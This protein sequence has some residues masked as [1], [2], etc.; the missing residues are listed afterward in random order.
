M[1]Q[2]TLN[3]LFKE[4]RFQSST[5]ETVMFNMAQKAMVQEFA[6]LG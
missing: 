1:A 5:T 2:F 3:V 4:T 6:K